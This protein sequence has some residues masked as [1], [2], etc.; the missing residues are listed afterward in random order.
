MD[1]ARQIESFQSIDKKKKQNK[2]R[3]N[4]STTAT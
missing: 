3:F 2:N 1:T 4:C